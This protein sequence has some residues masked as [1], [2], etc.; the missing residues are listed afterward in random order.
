MVP[1][2]SFQALLDGQQQAPPGAASVVGADLEFIDA[3]PG[4]SPGG[5]RHRRVD[6]GQAP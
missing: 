2:R 5:L 1:N 3:E 6:A 4:P